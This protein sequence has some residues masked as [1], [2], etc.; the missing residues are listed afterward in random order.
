MP[1]WVRRPVPWFGFRG[2][3]VRDRV[4]ASLPASLPGHLSPTLLHLQPEG[5]RTIVRF[6]FAQLD[7]VPDSEQKKL[8][9]KLELFE[10]L[11]PF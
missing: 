4:W 9:Q 7:A 2:T 1:S 5:I 10:V 8:Q 11:P 3:I 6:F